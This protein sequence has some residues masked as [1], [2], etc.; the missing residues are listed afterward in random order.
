MKAWWKRA[1]AI[2]VL[3]VTASFGLWMF[4][5]GRAGEAVSSRHADQQRPLQDPD[6]IKRGEY[7]SIAGDCAACHTAKGGKPYAGGHVLPTPFGD[8]AAPN[9]TPDRETGIGQWRFE[10]F[11][12][13]LHEG[14]GLDGKL[15]YP[16]FPYT[17]YTKVTRADARAIFAYL[18]SLPAVDRPDRKPHL[19]FPYSIRKGLL[20]WR[21]LYFDEG[22]YQPQP[23]RSEQWNRGAYLVEGLGHCNE[24]HTTRNA[25]GGLKEDHYLGGG[26]IPAQGWFAPDLSM[27]EGGGLE[28]WSRQDVVELLKTGRSA[29]GAVLGPMADV[30]R[31]STQHMTRVD[32]EAIAVYLESLPG[33]GPGAT[34]AVAKA[35]NLDAGSEVYASHCAACH[36][37]DGRGVPGIYPPLDGNSSVTGPDGINAIRTTLLGGFAPATAGNPEPYSMPPFAPRLEDEQIAA[38]VNYIRQSWSNQ[39][40]AVTAKDVQHYRYHH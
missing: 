31:N 26:T 2:G 15:L 4:S 6:L 35:P 32:L 23:E 5:P 30:V 9:I 7:L 17:S 13:A 12:R 18:K 21:A 33:R 29:K 28:G 40:G 25:L 37:K 3:L 8:V 14:K 39:A 20:V 36:G 1:A 24:C 34:R 22:E 27:Q 38:V 10:D 16:V 19:K 11:R